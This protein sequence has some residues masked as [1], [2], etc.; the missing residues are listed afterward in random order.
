LARRGEGGGSLGQ[1]AEPSLYREHVDGGSLTITRHDRYDS[2]DPD[3]TN[4]DLR[5]A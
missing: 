5:E 1:T 2:A 3:R 4:A